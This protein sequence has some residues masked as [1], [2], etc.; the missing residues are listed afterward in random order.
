VCALNVC[1]IVWMYTQ[2]CTELVAHLYEFVC[3]EACCVSNN[4]AVDG[5]GYE[6]TGS[7]I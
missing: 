7:Q 6:L 3:V 5:F 2:S 1:V 4:A